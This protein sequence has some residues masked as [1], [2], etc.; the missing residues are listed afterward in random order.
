MSSVETPDGAPE[1][2]KKKR[3]GWRRYAFAGL[4]A[5]IVIVTFAF[6]LPK[7][8]DYR[9]VWGVVKTLTWEWV[10]VLVGAT[11]LNLVTFAPPW[12]VTLPGLRFRQA[13]AMTQASTALSIIAPV[14]RRSGMAGSWGCSARGASVRPTSRGRSR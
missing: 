1:L 14:E 9:E 10:L 6:A 8:A 3:A 12:M 7:I 2:R 13:F 5:A 11:V 4:G